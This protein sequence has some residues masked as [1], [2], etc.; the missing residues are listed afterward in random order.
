[1]ARGVLGTGDHHGRSP[2]NPFQHRALLVQYSSNAIIGKDIGW[3][4]L[5][6]TSPDL[7]LTDTSSSIVLRT[8]H[9]YG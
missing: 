9:F 3:D 5:E 6:R 1:M 7:T 8:I 4:L 2:V